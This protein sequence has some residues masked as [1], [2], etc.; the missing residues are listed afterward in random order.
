[1]S[2]STICNFR[3][4]NI[5]HFGSSLFGVGK[6]MDDLRSELSIGDG[7]GTKPSYIIEVKFHAAPMWVL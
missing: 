1:M 3:Q 5:N 4:C 6:G 2:I 7:L